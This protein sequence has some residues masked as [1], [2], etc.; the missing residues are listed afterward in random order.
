[1]LI[2]I[3]A[4]V[5]AAAVAA[6]AFIVLVFFCVVCIIAGLAH[7][8]D[9]VLDGVVVVSEPS[10]SI[11][12][13]S[14]GNLYCTAAANNS[15]FGWIQ[16]GALISFGTV[17]FGKSGARTA[18][19][20]V[21]VDPGYAGGTIQLLTTKSGQPET[22]SAVF[23]LKSTGGWNEYKEIRVPLKAT[24]T[25]PHQVLFRI[26]GNGSCNFAAWKFLAD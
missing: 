24:L 19:V 15:Y 18:I 13:D 6:I 25:G 9:E 3:S 21:A 14:S 23:P 4:A 2:S 5:A 17:D 1:M 8:E 10:R 7:T 20:K 26:N 22:V 16:D 11:V 12:R